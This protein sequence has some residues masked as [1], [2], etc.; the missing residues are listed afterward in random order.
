MTARCHVMQRLEQLVLAG[1]PLE[2]ET[3]DRWI[4]E[5]TGARPG[6]AGGNRTLLTCQPIFKF[7]IALSR[8]IISDLAS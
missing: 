4:M 3:A 1:I 7:K 6:T 2:S 8:L 5:A